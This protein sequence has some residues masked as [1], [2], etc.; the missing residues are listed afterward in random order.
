ML[1]Q[2]PPLPQ[3]PLLEQIPKVL[4][5]D[6]SRSFPSTLHEIGHFLQEAKHLAD[7]VEI[8][9]TKLSQ[10]SKVVNNPAA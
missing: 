9:T 2:L 7:Q 4:A 5:D 8:E 1:P 6:D 3:L 10:Q